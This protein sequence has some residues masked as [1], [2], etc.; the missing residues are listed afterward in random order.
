MNEQSSNL[1][2]PV[3]FEA[4]STPAI[5]AALL[6]LYGRA[7]GEIAAHQPVCWL[8]GRCCD[9]DRFDHRLYVTGL[10]VAWVLSRPAAEQGQTVREMLG[11]EV[12]DLHGPCA[13][14]VGKRCTI[15]A[16]R[17]LGCR[18]FF[19]DASTRGWQQEIYE[20]YLAELRRVHDEHH[21][22]YAY[23]EWR[24]GVT[25]ALEQ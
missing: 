13:L 10:E 19:C 23:L 17:A 16:V 4:A 20:R 5:G 3:W 12:I 2:W 22:P 6:D 7:D 24:E 18:V 11:D 9:F 21:V 15:H 14:Q 8:S 25:A 1:P